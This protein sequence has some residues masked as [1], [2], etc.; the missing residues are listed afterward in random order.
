MFECATLSSPEEIIRDVRAGKMVILV[1]DEDRENEGDLV[2]AAEAVTPEIINFMA[3][4]AC[5]LICLTLT[6]KRCQ[7]LNLRPMVEDNQSAHTTAFTV[8]IEAA[9]GVTTGISAHDRAKTVQVAVAS[10]A[11]RAD[12][13]SPGHI[14]PLCAKDGGVL[15]RMGH[16]EAGTDLARLA[17][18]EPAS[19]ICEIV[20]ADGTMARL[21][22]L[23]EFGKKHGIRV[24]SIESLVAYRKK[25]DRQVWESARTL[26]I[27][28][29]GVFEKVSFSDGVDAKPYTVLVRGSQRGAESFPVGVIRLAV[30]SPDLGGL[31]TDPQ[32]ELAELLVRT[33]LERGGA[34]VV[35]R[36][37][38]AATQLTEG[39]VDAL[40]G[41]VVVE[42]IVAALGIEN[43]A[44]SDY[45]VLGHAMLVQ[46]D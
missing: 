23:L 12:I 44:L 43:P 9:H 22:Q 6:R 29:F 19:V 30:G 4:E 1:D 45:G 10:G 34:I 2:V 37:E 7:Q 31:L 5:G 46:M 15:A 38:S 41:Q 16:T 26:V 35:L 21:P 20:N 36:E 18:F 11:T 17:G 25:H 39:R 33:S 42:K 27:S 32:S 3:R 40:S 13:V 24:G 8:S 28:D 14:F